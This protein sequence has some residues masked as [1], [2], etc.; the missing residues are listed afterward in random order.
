MRHDS[1]TNQ[2]TLQGLFTFAN[3]S[4]QDQ[5]SWE[6]E[7]A[8]KTSCTLEKRRKSTDTWYSNRRVCGRSDKDRGEVKDGALQ[9]VIP[10]HPNTIWWV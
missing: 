10:T 5:Q 9:D 6:T 1:K 7:H 2:Y 4:F 3:S 8:N